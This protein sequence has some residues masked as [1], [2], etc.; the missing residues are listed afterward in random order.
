MQPVSL[1]SGLESTWSSFHWLPKYI[2]QS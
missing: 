2:W 1:L